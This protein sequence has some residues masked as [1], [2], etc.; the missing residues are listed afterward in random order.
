MNI[1]VRVVLEKSK[2]GQERFDEKTATRVP[3]VYFC[4]MVVVATAPRGAWP[5]AL[6]GYYDD[7]RDYLAH[8]CAAAKDP[9]SLAAWLAREGLVPRSA[10]E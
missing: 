9:Q 4:F 6:P 10:A 3:K 1:K 8:Y 2:L 5:L 7:D